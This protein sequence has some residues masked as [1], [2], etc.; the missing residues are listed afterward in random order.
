MTW[1]GMIGVGSLSGCRDRLA[2]DAPR[3]LVLSGML[4]AFAVFGLDEE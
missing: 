3:D 1:I 4:V 2:G